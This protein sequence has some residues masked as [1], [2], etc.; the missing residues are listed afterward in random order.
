M[1]FYGVGTVFGGKTPDATEKLNE[2]LKENFWCMGFTDEE[3]PEYAELIRQIKIGDIIIAKSYGLNA[4]YYVKAIGVV[5]DTKMPESIVENMRKKSGVSVLWVKKFEPYIQLTKDNFCLGAD[6]P[7]TIYKENNEKN[8]SVI[9]KLMKFNYS[10][11][12]ENDYVK[13]AKTFVLYRAKT[14][15]DG[16]KITECA[17]NDVKIE[18]GDTFGR[19]ILLVPIIVDE[20]IKYSLILL[21]PDK[22]RKDDPMSLINVRTE[23]LDDTENLSERVSEMK[24]QTS[25]GGTL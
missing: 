20:T 22:E 15:Y 9:K 24:K 18:A 7:R 19:K 11:I 5:I 8:I 25:W 10:C 6:R 4:T 21:V 1:N 2:F 12:K 23:F 16:L 3:R 13:L 17:N 14:E